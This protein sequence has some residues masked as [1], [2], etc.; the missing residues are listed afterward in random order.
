MENTFDVIIIG[1]GPAGTS[2]ATALAMKGRSVVVIEKDKFPRYHIGE[3][4]IPF[5][6]FPLEKIGMIDKMKN[7]G[8]VNKYSVRFVTIEGKMSAPFY[9]SQHMNHAAANTWQVSRA[10]FDCMLMEHAREHGAKVREEAMALELLREN[11]N[12]VGVKVAPKDGE[13]YELRAPVTI[14]ASG[15][16]AMTI[17]QNKW[18]NWDQALNKISIWTYFR[19]AMRDPGMDEGATTVAYLPDKGWFWYIPLEDDVVSIGL[20]AE[21]DYLFNE[22][23]SLPDIFHR[24][25]GR[26]NWIEE[27]L[28]PGKQFGEYFMTKE[29]SYRAEHCAE[30][31]LVLVG[32]AFAFLDPVFS[33]GVYLA[34]QSGVLAAE[35]IDKALST[36]NTSAAAFT[37]YGEKIC[38]EIEAMRKLV[39]AFYDQTFSFGKLI[40]AN[41]HLRGDLT[42]CLIGDL[43]K[44]FTELFDAVNK[45][46]E[47]P[48]PLPHGRPAV[49][50]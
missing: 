18:R 4:L 33:S 41:P 49:N 42:D 7:A 22:T 44:D 23:K 12:V 48:Q 32:D 38:T 11:G 36:N 19:G 9:F 34:L 3:S 2:A 39:Y 26:N 17:N 43:S 15:R 13:H 47:V 27:H 21:K 40:K 10:K 29:F 35:A 37:D 14:D 1:G 24:E 20:V 30:N 31:G 5:C 50:A 16:Q 45:I 8:F 6:Y 28:K 46:A 25:V